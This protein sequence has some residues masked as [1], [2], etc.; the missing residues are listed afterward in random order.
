MISGHLFN[1]TEESMLKM[2]YSMPNSVHIKD[3]RSGRYIA[4]NKHNLKTY[5][6]TKESELLGLTFDDLNDFMIPYW[7]KYFVKIMDD[8]D[9]RIKISEKVEVLNNLIFKDKRNFIRHQNLYK[10][11]LFH[12]KYSKKMSTVFTMTLEF[13]DKLC[14]LYL[15]EQYKIMHNNKYEALQYFMR[16]LDIEKFFYEPLTEKELMC[17]LYAKKNQSHK[18]VASNLDISIKTVETHMGNITNKLRKT[19]IQ[20]VISFLRS[21]GEC[22]KIG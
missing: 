1:I 7:G 16:Y 5:G 18:S 13:T 4:T 11:P 19:T 22:E 6:F 15:F 20:E 10:I 9:N 8:F 12:N 21:R 17:L 3:A 14:L 2:I